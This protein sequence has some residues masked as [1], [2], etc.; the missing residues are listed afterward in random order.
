MTS[1]QENKLAM[2][3]AVKAV[4]ATHQQDWST[5]PAFG[6]DHDELLAAIDRIV[7]LARKRSSFSSAVKIKNSARRELTEAVLET[8][9]AM[10]ALAHREGNQELTELTEPN[11]SGL[12]RLR[13]HAL[14][15]YG[16]DLID[17]GRVHLP[18]LAA[19][20]VTEARVNALQGCVDSYQAAVAMPRQ[21]AADVKATTR[22]LAIEFRTADDLLDNRLDR[23]ILQLRSGAPAFC[24]AYEHA[25]RIVGKTRT[26]TPSAEPTPPAEA[27]MLAAA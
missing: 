3:L 16:Q 14:V 8:A 10:R 5:L 25:R 9:G 18:A 20:G 4:C 22:Q 19:Y 11:R 1:Q 6:Q 26:K 13:G 7:A 21:V 24:E 15:R 27:P 12:A 17:T 2:F 23:L